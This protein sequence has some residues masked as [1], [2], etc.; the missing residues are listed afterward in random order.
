METDN[1]I[2]FIPNFNV[3]VMEELQKKY[4]PSDNRIWKCPGCGYMVSDATFLTVNFNPEC[5]CKE[6]NWSQFNST[7]RVCDD[8]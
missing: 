2:L 4:K 1:V 7:M 3:R 6:F 5:K 8:D